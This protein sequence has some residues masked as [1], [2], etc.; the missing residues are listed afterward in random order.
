MRGNLQTVTDVEIDIN[1]VFIGENTLA[2]N[3][4][5]GANCTIINSTIGEGTLIHP[6]SI[7]ENAVLGSDCNVGP[8][9]RLR[10][11]A[12]LSDKTR[13]ENFVE[14][15]NAEIGHGSKVNHL[16]YVGDAETGQ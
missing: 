14:I 13:V 3:V 1:V 8:F 4:S 11:G 9:A 10:P 5:I 6:N 16:S 7:V 12:R 2:D 15:K